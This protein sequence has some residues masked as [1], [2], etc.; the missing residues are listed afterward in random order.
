MV[1]LGIEVNS[2]LFTLRIPEDKMQEILNIL[3]AWTNKQFCTIKELQSLAGLLNFATRCVRSGRVYLARILN[4][5]WE[6]SAKGLHKIPRETLKDVQWWKDF[7]PMYNGVSMMLNNEWNEPDETLASDRCLTGGGMYIRNQYLHFE[8]PPKVLHICKHIN[9]L[10]C[11]TLVL[12]VAKWA[13]LFTCQKIQLFCDNQVTVA[14]INSGFSHN[15]VLQSCLR[16]LHRIMAIESFDLRAV[17]LSS[18][19]NIATDCLSRWHLHESHRLEFHKFVS[20]RKMTEVRVEPTDFD[21]L[22]L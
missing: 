18:S 11:V 10:E 9:Q 1:F 15:E 6:L 4:F 20:N 12:A 7:F 5:L 21:F 2:I 22:F 16:Y 3:E 13:H 8:F 17:F 14:C 19:Q